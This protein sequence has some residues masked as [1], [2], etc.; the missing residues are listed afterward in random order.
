MP[1]QPDLLSP[2][3]AC[4]FLLDGGEM[5]ARMRAHD[6]STTPLGS[7]ETWPQS[8]K[9]MV[10]ACLNSPLLG[11][12]LWGPEL[13]MLYNDAYIASLADRHPDALGR[14]VAEVWEKLGTK[15]LRRS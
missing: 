14:P 9:T 1:S 3:P 7:P 4:F 15:S 10:A 11:A 6:W 12:V 13:V 8:L 2:N 5:G